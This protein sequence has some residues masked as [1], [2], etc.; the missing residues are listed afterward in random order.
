MIDSD[1]DGAQPA[2]GPSRSSVRP[3]PRRLS[4]V[5]MTNE[6]D[7]DGVEVLEIR[8]TPAP[9]GLAAVAREQSRR[10]WE[11]ERQRTARQREA[12]AFVAHLTQ[13]ATARNNR[14][15]EPAQAGGGPLPPFDL[16][17]VLIGMPPGRGGAHARR[18]ALHHDH[19]LMPPPLHILLMLGGRLGD[20]IFAHLQDLGAAPRPNNGATEEQI[21]AIPTH[22]MPNSKKRARRDDEQEG[23]E[24]DELNC[25]ICQEEMKPGEKVSTLPCSHQYHTKCINQWLKTKK[26]RGARVSD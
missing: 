23:E 17:R 2:A 21:R 1:D 10:V 9:S 18:N 8:P 5:D 4:V 11:R 16:G 12:E 14:A 13:R 22:T 7:D 25:I 15:G 26:V 19:P 6:E 20:G 24:D 3:S